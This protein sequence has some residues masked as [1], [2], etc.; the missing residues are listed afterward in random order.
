MVH[1][2]YQQMEAEQIISSDE[3]CGM[4]LMHMQLKA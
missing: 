2:L 4:Q 1:F 3:D